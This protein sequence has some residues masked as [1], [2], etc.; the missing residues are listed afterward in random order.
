MH[1]RVRSCIALLAF[2]L[3]PPAAT[4]ST[5]KAG[6][7]IEDA[8]DEV[9]DSKKA[10][11]RA[12]LGALKDARDDIDDLPSDPSSKALRS[13]ERTLKDVRKDARKHCDESVVDE[14][15]RALRYIRD[16]GEDEDDDDRRTRRRK[17]RR[18]PAAL[19]HS[20]FSQL[21]DKLQSSKSRRHRMQALE[22]TVDGRTL[23]SIQL[24][25]VITYFKTDQ[26]KA[27]AIGVCAPHLSDPQNAV[28]IPLT[29]GDSKAQ[30]DA[31][32]YIAQAQ[33]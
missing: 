24:G 1:A 29:I 9:R 22:N 12:V 31:S 6:A 23:T 32:R 27:E 7:A 11:R 2:M 19:T 13:V 10:C 18:A 14:I 16:A 30:A 15:R 3:L 26:R 28:L 21:Q 5:R 33:P 8:I 25:F 17:K 20:E 4:A